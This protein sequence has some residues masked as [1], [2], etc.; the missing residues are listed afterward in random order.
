MADRGKGKFVKGEKTNEAVNYFTQWYGT[1]AIEWL[2]QFQFRKNDELEVLTTVAE[3]MADLKRNSLTITVES[4]KQVIQSNSEWSPKLDKIY[5]NDIN[6]QSAMR[7]SQ[8]L[9]A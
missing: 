2:K 4:I 3:A 8:K 5:F 1:D 6:I 7:E 9:F